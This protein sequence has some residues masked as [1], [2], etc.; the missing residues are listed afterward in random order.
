M[1]LDRS[2]DDYLFTIIPVTRAI[3]HGSYQF[4]HTAANGGSETERTSRIWKLAL[5]YV[6][7][8]LAA[9]LAMC[10]I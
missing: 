6:L 8:G 3:D 5:I 7:L 9:L 4:V 1:H 10:T 2:A